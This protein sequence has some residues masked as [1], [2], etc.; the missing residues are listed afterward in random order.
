MFGENVKVHFAG[1]DGWE[2]FHAAARAAD[3]RY[4]LYSCYRFIINKTIDDDLTLPID[5]TIRVQD[6]EFK[7]VIQDSGLFTLMFG[8]M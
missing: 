2:I 7:H 4:A 1:V 6:R 3:V 5:H 8:K